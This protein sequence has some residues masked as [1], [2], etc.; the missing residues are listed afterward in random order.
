MRTGETTSSG[1]T[2]STT[3]SSFP[4]LVFSNGVLDPVNSQP[5]ENLEYRRKQLNRARD[6]ES[7]TESAYNDFLYRV[8]TAPNE[9][10]MLI[11]T[12]TLLKGYKP[13]YHP[14]YSQSLADF[15]KNVGFNNGLSAA[16]PD[17]IEGID[18]TQSG[19]FPVHD[20][21][22]GAAVPTLERHAP[23]LSHL[24]GE[25]KGPGK[26]MICAETQAA[27]DGACLVYGRNKA[28]V[29]LGNP[30][31]PGHAYVSSFTTDGTILNTY[32]HYSSQFESQVKYHQY[33]TST[34][35]L[36]SSYE[37]FKTARRRLRNE[38]DDAKE[39][40]E[41]LMDELNKKWSARQPYIEV[42]GEDN[43]DDD[44]RNDDGYIPPPNFHD[45]LAKTADAKDYNGY[46]HYDEGNKKD[47]SASQRL[48]EH[49][50][51][52]TSKNRDADEDLGDAKDEEFVQI[53]TPDASSSSSKRQATSK[54]T[55]PKAPRRST[56][57][58]S[59]RQRSKKELRQ[60]E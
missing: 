22:G 1:K 27:Y 28:R 48:A 29:Y 3:D 25:W 37:D 41:K 55:V 34:S 49:R 47:E 8:Q 7:P 10:S 57:T 40:S 17:M 38:Q 60:L 18:L 33:P 32:T 50:A 51:S 56:G 43:N 11:A 16:Q 6:T 45:V 31:P 2:V 58:S 12:S 21:L 15:P 20:V 36:R 52:F 4:R 53:P 26:D 24:A 19:P 5:P 44:N 46:D 35:L 13:G 9:M 14:V 23:A 59:R 30:D 54:K 39:N 42:G